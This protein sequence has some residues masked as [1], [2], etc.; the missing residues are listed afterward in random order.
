MVCVFGRETWRSRE[1]PQWRVRTHCRGGEE[2]PPLGSSGSNLLSKR[3]RAGLRELRRL[4]C[5]SRILQNRWASR[6]MRI[7]DTA[8]TPGISLQVWGSRGERDESES[9]PLIYKAWGSLLWAS[10]SKRCVI[11][12]GE[13]LFSTCD[14]AQSRAVMWGGQGL[15]VWSLT[16]AK[17]LDLHRLQ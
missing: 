12:P 3:W 1:E 5:S 11:P 2:R 14:E 4:G 13:N 10:W 17:K 9:F 16:A 8:P 15:G 7:P 6:S